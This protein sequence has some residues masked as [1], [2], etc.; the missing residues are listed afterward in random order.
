[1]ELWDIYDKD[2]KPTGETMVSGSE[3]GEGEYHLIV[4]LCIFNSDGQLLIQQRQSSKKQ[5]PNLLDLSVG[6][7]A[8][9][10]E[11]SQMAGER[12]LKEELGYIVNLQKKRPIVT[13]HYTRGFDDVFIIEENLDLAELTLQQEEVQDVK[14]ATKEEIISKIKEGRFVPYFESFIHFLFDM[15]SHPN[16]YIR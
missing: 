9:S 8:I 7:K 3:F 10:G 4:H 13:I 15:F 11:T 1:M 14:W 2:R 6:E 5:W 16:S 12:E